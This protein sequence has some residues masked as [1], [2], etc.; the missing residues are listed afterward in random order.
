MSM[1][2]SACQGLVVKSFLLVLHTSQCLQ[3]WE[4]INPYCHTPGKAGISLTLPL[5]ITII[6]SLALM[7]EE[8]DIKLT[9]VRYPFEPTNHGFSR[10]EII[11]Q[12]ESLLKHRNFC[13]LCNRH[14]WLISDTNAPPYDRSFRYY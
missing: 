7:L 3:N 12:H 8:T 9:S 2:L 10:S 11:S 13:H 1:D 14:G 6:Y 4:G 5:A